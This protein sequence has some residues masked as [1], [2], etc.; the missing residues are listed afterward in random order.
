MTCPNPLGRGKPLIHAAL[1]ASFVLIFLLTSKKWSRGRPSVLTLTGSPEPGFVVRS[2]LA[3]LS[4]SFFS[5]NVAA[6][7]NGVPLL[8]PESVVVKITKIRVGF[9]LKMEVGTGF[10]L[11]SNCDLVAT[12]YHGRRLACSS[13]L[14]ARASRKNIWLPGPMTMG[15]YGI[16]PWMIPLGPQRNRRPSGIWQFLN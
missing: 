4:L 3:W 12:N 8:K 10:C 2:F 13:K 6:Q 11:N 9:P 16:N 15:P 5:A 1:S 14:K 7:K